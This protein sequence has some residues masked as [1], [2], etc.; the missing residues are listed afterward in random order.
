M[1]AN[2]GQF[3]WAFLNWEKGEGVLYH[4]YSAL[5]PAALRKPASIATPETAAGVGK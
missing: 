4:E 1:A 3:G 2:A 5:M